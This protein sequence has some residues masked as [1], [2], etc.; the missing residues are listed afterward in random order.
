MW[1][2]IKWS[3]TYNLAHIGLHML[4]TQKKSITLK[5]YHATAFSFSDI[6][7]MGLNKH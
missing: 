6:L 4:S 5:A 2:D 3:I 1:I 7:S